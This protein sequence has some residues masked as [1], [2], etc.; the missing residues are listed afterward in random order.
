LLAWLAVLQLPGGRLHVAFLDVG[1]GDAILNTA[2]GGQQILADRGPGS[3][4][5][6][7]TLPTPAPS[8]A[9]WR[10]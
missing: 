2:L 5:L 8:P 3:A 6:A 1:R 7:M 10:S 4:A 9:W